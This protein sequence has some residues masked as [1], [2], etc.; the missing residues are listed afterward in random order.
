MSEKSLEKIKLVYEFNHNSPVFARVAESFMNNGEYD[1]ALSILEKGLEKYPDY[2]SAK[3]VLIELLS[4]KND[5]KRLINVVD[6]IRDL[7]DEKTVNYYLDKAE[8]ERNL[9]TEILGSEK[10]EPRSIEDNLENLADTISKAK[11][12]PASDESVSSSE[13]PDP[14]PKGNQF[15][16]ETLAEIYLMQSN[17]KEALSIYEKLLESNPNK[18]EHYKSKIDEIKS[19]MK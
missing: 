8:E 18:A 10:G 9:S 12:P 6:E 15:I 4:K 2:V 17:Y 19:K 13:L 16:S 11:I 3:I 7:V 5:Y 14:T 1:H